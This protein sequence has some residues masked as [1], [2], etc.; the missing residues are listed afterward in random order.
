SAIEAL[1]EAPPRSRQA[2]RILERAI[3]QVSA[4]KRLPLSEKDSLTSALRGLKRDSI[5]ATCGRLIR[6]HC[7]TDAEREFARAYRMRSSVLHRAKTPRAAEVEPVLRA[8]ERIV[9]R[10]LIALI[11]KSA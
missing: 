4:S 7:G 3:T 2:V 9:Q 11:N 8:L 10:V 1:G 5:G 6:E